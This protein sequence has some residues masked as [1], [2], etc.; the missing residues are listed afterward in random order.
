[1]W[2]YDITAG[3]LERDGKHVFTGGYTGNGAGLNN[4][5]MEAVQGVGPL[6]EGTYRMT[7]LREHGASTGPY[8]IVLEQVSGE[9]HGRSAFRIHGD[10]SKGDH[11][12][13][14]GC[15]IL[16]PQVRHQIWESGDHDLTVVA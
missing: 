1:M 10:N 5:E 16:P 11:S 15:I 3:R 8:T 2:T 9:T 4:P 6:P 14:H 13:S 7:E 12:A